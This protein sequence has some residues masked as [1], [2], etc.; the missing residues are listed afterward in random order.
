MAQNSSIHPSSSN[1]YQISH[2]L[3]NVKSKSCPT[4]TPHTIKYHNPRINATKWQRVDVL[5]T[6][7]VYR[8]RGN[9]WLSPWWSSVA[10]QTDRNDSKSR[11]EI[12]WAQ[13]SRIS[14][15]QTIRMKETRTE[16]SLKIWEK[17]ARG[18]DWRG[19]DLQ[20][21]IR[22]RWCVSGIAY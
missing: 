17:E 10:A 21:L 5:I 3:G 16:L 8:W 20:V 13:N 15:I 9:S 12:D 22:N 2:L 14:R 7:N 6:S 11:A 18:R 1:S 19:S 4:H